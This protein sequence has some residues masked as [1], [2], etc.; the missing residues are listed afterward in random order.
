MLRG[1]HQPPPFSAYQLPSP[2]VA[3]ARAGTATRT[4]LPTG[5]VAG[6]SA[7]G[8]TV[9]SAPMYHSRDCQ[10]SLRS[11][12]HRLAPAGLTNVT[13]RDYLFFYTGGGGGGGGGGDG[14][15]FGKV[16]LGTFP[17]LGS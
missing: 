15:L 4:A 10:T 9:L 6:P 2:P 5:S 7:A 11:E 3:P 17:L 14:R 12:H 8:S 1:L 13:V 16:H